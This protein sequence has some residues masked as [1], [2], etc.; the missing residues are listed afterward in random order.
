MKF[1]NILGY[2]VTGDQILGA[3]LIILQVVAIIA[4]CRYR[5]KKERGEK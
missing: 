5:A 1:Y 4:F 2:W 3:G